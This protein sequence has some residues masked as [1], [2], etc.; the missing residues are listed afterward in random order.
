MRYKAVDVHTSALITSGGK[1]ELKQVYFLRDLYQPDYR[2]WYSAR[3]TDQQDE[4]L[5]PSIF[6]NAP[7]PSLTAHQAGFHIAESQLLIAT[8]CTSPVCSSSPPRDR[9]KWS[10]LQRGTTEPMKAKCGNQ[11]DSRHSAGG[12]R[13]NK[14]RPAR[15]STTG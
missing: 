2:A 6:L 10:S 15:H 14:Q 3:S 5:S 13:N 7:M 1:M 12:R 11:G 8:G 9:S 4:V